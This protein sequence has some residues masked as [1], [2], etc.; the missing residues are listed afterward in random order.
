MK[1]KP[2][3]NKNAGGG[4]NPLQLDKNLDGF[5]KTKGLIVGAK[6]DSVA[7]NQQVQRAK[8]LR[9][10]ITLSQEEQFNLFEMVP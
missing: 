1:E 2:Q 10:I 4:Y 3:A 7:A 5:I 8:E 6:V 9:E